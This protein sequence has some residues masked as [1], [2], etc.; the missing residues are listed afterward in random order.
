V[1]EVTIRSTVAGTF[2]FRPN[3]VIFRRSDGIVV[4]Q[5]PGEPTTL[6][7]AADERRVARLRLGPLNLG[8]ETYVF[9]VGLFRKL[10]LHAVEPP[11]RYDAIDRGFEFRIFGREANFRAVFQHPGEWEIV[12]PTAQTELVSRSA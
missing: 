5:Q 4:S 8:N 12:V 2:P 1:V 11:E 10:D 6:T 7:L 3:L 9:S